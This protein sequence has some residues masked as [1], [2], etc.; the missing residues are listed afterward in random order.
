MK[1]TS[2]L[3]RRATTLTAALRFLD[4]TP[5]DLAEVREAL[6]CAVKDNDRASDRRRAAF[7]RSCR[8]RRPGRT[9]WTLNE[10]VR[11][12]LEL[13]HGEAARATGYQCGRNSR[14]ACLSSKEIGSNYNKSMLESYSQ[15]RP[16]NGWRLR[17]A[18]REV[19]ISFHAKSEPNEVCARGA[20]HRPRAERGELCLVSL[21]HS[22]RQSPMAWA[23]ACR[24]A[25]RLSK[26]TADGCGR[27]G[28]SR[29]VLSFSLRS[30]LTEPPSVIDVA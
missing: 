12:V 3:R 7:V 9:A 18:P 17:T 15:R 24:S 5:P 8:K 21:N 4:R 30:P 26:P 19:L 11:E 22:T 6:A 10:A 20:G 28:A 13:T 16:S 23:W 1:S 2:R 25:A 14:T 29:G 27:P